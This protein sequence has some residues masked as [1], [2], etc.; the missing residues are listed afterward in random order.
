MLR[1]AET[2]RLAWGNSETVP[3]LGED[4]QEFYSPSPNVLAMTSITHDP[5][6]LLREVFGYPTFRGHQED[7]IHHVTAGGDAF[8]LM[9]TGGGKSLCYQLPALLRP[10]VG[11]VVSPLIALMQDQVRAMQLLGVRASF[12]NSTLSPEAA[13]EVERQVLAGELDLLYVAPE[14]L[15]NER[16][17]SLLDRSQPRALRD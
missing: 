4:E 16:T 15:L 5:H 2:V 12:L 9:P 7:I 10:G 8:V 11:V 1:G 17:L 13:C 6:A 3:E 14:R